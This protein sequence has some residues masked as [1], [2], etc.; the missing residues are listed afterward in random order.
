MT[1]PQGLPALECLVARELAQTAFPAAPWV[2]PLVAPDGA[3]ALDCAIIGGGQYGLALAGLLKRECVTRIAVFDAARAGMEG[4]W[5]NF[6]RM[7]MLRTP[8]DL[9]GPEC[10]LPSLT[11]RAWWEAQHGEASWEAMYRIPRT[12]WAAYLT[13]F[14]RV[15][16]LPVRNGWR[17]REMQPTADGTMIGLLFET[18]DGPLLRHARSVVMATGTGGA[19]GYAIPAPI[20]RALPPG[21]VVHANDIL[22][23]GAFAGERVGVLGA[24]ATAFDVAI[25]ALQAGATRAEVCVRRPELPRDNPRRWMESAGHLAHYVD[26]PD[27]AKWAYATRLRQIGQPPPQPTFDAAMAE[28]GFRLRTGMPWDQVRWTGSEIIVEGNGKRLVFDRLVIAT[29]FTADMALKSEYAAL[30]PHAALWRDRFTPPAE[31]ADARLG[32]Q[33]YLDRFGGFTERL[34]GA[35]PWLGRV[36]TITN[37]ASLSLGP[38]AASISAMKYVAPRLVEGV[39]RRLFLDQQESDWAWFLGGD[40]AELAPFNQPPSTLPETVAA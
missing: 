39:K 6:A 28:P 18:P 25:A 31:Q 16:D 38:V 17:L 21:R 32:R 20:A 40:H 9:A 23:L 26:L 30:L 12:A 34:P 8:K 22:D 29:G 1:C 15:L 4:P 37:N 2:A 19:G 11:F 14:R 5:M 35:A 13:W 33:P 7:T 3:E 24:G 27:A 10:G 36:F